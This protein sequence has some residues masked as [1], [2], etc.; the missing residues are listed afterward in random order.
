MEK[1]VI[2]YVHSKQVPMRAIIAAWWELCKDLFRGGLDG[3]AIV[4]IQKEECIWHHAYSKEHTKAML[5]AVMHMGLTI[6]KELDD[7]ESSSNSST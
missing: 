1:P 6:K 7:V 5:N 3:F 2:T 4:Y